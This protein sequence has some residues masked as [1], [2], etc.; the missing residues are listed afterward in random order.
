MDNPIYQTGDEIKFL[1]EELKLIK[2]KLDKKELKGEIAEVGVMWGGSAKIIT[3]I[4]PDKTVYLFDTFEGLPDDMDYTVDPTD[5]F[6]GAMAVD[7]DKVKKFLKNCNVKIYPG[8]FP[9][10][11]SKYIKD[12]KF[13]FVHIDVDIYKATKDTLE[14]FYPRLEVGGSI[15]IHD[16][17]L[18]R[19]VQ[20]AVDD[21]MENKGT[22]QKEK[23]KKWKRDYL[24]RTA[25]RQ[26]II[27]KKYEKHN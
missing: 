11:T 23:W 27:R 26:L 1:K 22:F 16:Y 18:H 19:G 10:E 13:A 9:Q 25:F 4:I 17:P 3:K 7:L 24:I 5:Y 8:I 12:K 6:V 2:E 20:K 14:F 15:V 21:F